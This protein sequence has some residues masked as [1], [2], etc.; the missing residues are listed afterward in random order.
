MKKNINVALLKFV[1]LAIVLPLALFSTSC[2]NDEEN[3]SPRVSEVSM[4]TQPKVKYVLGEMLDLT[5]MVITLGKGENIKDVPYSSFGEE[6]ITTDP[7]NGK[8]LDFSDEAVIITIGDTGSGMI[9]AI[10][11]TNDIVALIVKT[12]PKANYVSGETLDLSGL[13]VTIVQEDGTTADVAFDD[14]GKKFGTTPMD[15]DVLAVENTNIVISYLES[16]AKVTQSI[17]VIA[18]EPVSATLVTGPTK[19]VYDIG[20]RLSLEGT[21][22]NYVLPGGLE[23]ELS[24]ED[25]AAFNITT[26]PAN[27]DKL[28]STDNE[29]QAMTASGNV[30]GIP[31]TVNQLDVTGM[32]M[33]FAPDKTLYDVG[34]LIDL[35]GLSVR[36]AVTGKDDVIVASEDFDIYGITTNPVE[37]TA[38]EEGT[39]EIV[40]SYPGIADTITISL[41]SEILY[42]SNFTDGIDGWTN[43]GNDGGSSNVYAQD[44]VMIS[45]N[46]VVGTNTYS[47]QLYKPSIT[48]EKDAKYKITIE[49]M[50]VP[51]EGGFDFSFS[52]GDGDGRDGY[53]NY[54]G[55]ETLSLLGSESTI[56]TG[57][58]TMSN[59]TTNAAR[60][61][62]NNGYQTNSVI[63][64]YVKFEKL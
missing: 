3:D 47:L 44:G 22:I 41:G 34:E 51:G 61:L 5:G 4:K 2:S 6:G 19:N 42:E 15:G 55:N 30:V 27:E 39:T 62:L 13:V 43:Q 21:V 37:G 23:V 12:E 49:L 52:V 36:L 8:V 56:F 25:F 10:D 45:D 26:T 54:Y 29:V 60:I 57:E 7:E 18:F 17:D 46:I 58:F 32:T 35:N 59:N 14:F 53:Q 38:Y 64:K 11:V 1:A 24:F 33:E 40:V 16:E 31:I 48:L 9:Q 63:V 20:E 50:A 28:K